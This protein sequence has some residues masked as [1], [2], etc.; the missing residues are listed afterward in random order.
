MGKWL[1]LMEDIWKYLGGGKLCVSFV[2]VSVC[3][4]VTI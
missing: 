1:W 2:R 4:C 3:E